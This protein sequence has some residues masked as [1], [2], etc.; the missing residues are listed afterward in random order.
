MVVSLNAKLESIFISKAAEFLLAFPP[1]FVN[2]HEEPQEHLF[3]E[4]IFHV[5]SGLGANL[6]ER[7]ASFSDDDTLLA[8][9]HYIDY[10][11]DVISL[12]ALLEF[13]H[14]HL[15]AIWNLLLVVE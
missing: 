1:V 3:L 13:L 14:R 5:D 9:P 6:L 2:L 15:A 12:R 8:F 7:G 4:E 11:A 10:S